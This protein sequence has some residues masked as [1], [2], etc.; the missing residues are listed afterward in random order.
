MNRMTIGLALRY[1][2]FH[3]SFAAT[4]NGPGQLVPNRNISFPETDNLN[5]KDLTYR[6]ALTYD[7]MGNGKTALKLTLNKY[8]RGQTLNTLGG[9]PNPVNKLVNSTTR[10]WND[11]NRDFVPQCDILLPSANG[12]CGAMANANFGTSVPGETF[13]N[14]LLTGYGNRE[15]NW[16]FSAGV[17]HELLPRVS[18]DVGYF[19]RIWLNL[20]TTDDLAL[21]AA[22]FDVFSMTLPKD[23]RLPN[24]G[25]YTLEGLRNLKPTAFGRPTQNLNALSND[26]GKAIEHWNG[27]DIG[28]SARLQ[29]GL[30][31][32]FGTSTGKTSENDCE[33][34]AKLPELNSGT[35][36]RP[37]Q[38]C[39]R[40]TPYLTSAKGYA[41]Y[42][43]PKFDVQVSGTFRSTAET[44][45]NANFTA[46]NAYLAAN[47]TLGRPLS[48][49]AANITVALLEP[50]TKY[51]DR[52]NEL[53]LRFGKV[54][55]V[56]RARSVLS[57]DVFNALNSDAVLTVNQNYAAWLTPQSILNARLLKFSVQFDF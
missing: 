43:I 3:S 38:F 26:Y 9:T 39:D 28:V 7:L 25:G 14:T 32:Q 36:Q 40:S 4:E 15:A 10:S 18:L 41:V 12:E 45:I 33:V 17:Q 44:A 29:N 52:R 49:G 2:Y 20:A 19:R 24:G 35:N 46:T 48:G 56:G 57:I 6:S 51:L 27:V 54:L 5:W 53:D 23:P 55:R 22:D 30:M 31:L 16:E 42:T 1:D 21:T 47:S 34:A 13:S 50:N 8:L 37:L 11:A